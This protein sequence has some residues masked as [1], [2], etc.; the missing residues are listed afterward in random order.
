DDVRAPR[1]DR[2]LERA[3]AVS[4]GAIRVRARRDQEARGFGVPFRRRVHER[5]PPDV[6]VRDLLH[7]ADEG[8]EHLEDVARHARVRGRAAL[9]AV[10][11]LVACGRPP[12]SLDGERYTPLMRT[13]ESGDV[14]RI[15]AL[16]RRGA[17]VDYQGRE[18]TRYSLLWPF[19]TT[20]RENVPADSMTPLMIAAR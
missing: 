13:A 15:H 12:E 2:E 8:D 7:P 20:E 9:V 11:V 14:A 19:L 16:V 17:D 10:V 5:R 18:V 1:P 6:P 3:V 4:A